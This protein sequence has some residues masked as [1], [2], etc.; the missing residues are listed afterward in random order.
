[1]TLYDDVSVTPDI[2]GDLEKLPLY[3]GQGAGLVSTIKPAGE[4]VAEMTADAIAA[5]SLLGR[6]PKAR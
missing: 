6:S 1:M 3:A 2:D 5:L 4:I